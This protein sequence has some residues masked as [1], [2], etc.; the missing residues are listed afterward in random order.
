MPV[1]Q[2]GRSR[3][4]IAGAALTTRE[5]AGIKVRLSRGDSPRLI[6]Q[7]YDVGT[8]TIRRIGRGETWAWVEAA[9]FLIDPLAEI[10]PPEPLPEAVQAELAESAQRLLAL[11]ASLAEPRV[12]PMDLYL[13]RAKPAGPPASDALKIEDAPTQGKEGMSLDDLCLSLARISGRTAE[14]LKKEIEAVPQGAERN[15]LVT[16]IRRAGQVVRPSAGPYRG[17]PRTQAEA[18]SAARLAKISSADAEI[19]KLTQETQGE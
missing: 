9:E 12:D 1:S 10:I 16:K 7:D 15:A 13:S 2:Q 17:P 11:Q 4:R 19:E 6:A 18:L 3:Q 14:S 8:E 5:V